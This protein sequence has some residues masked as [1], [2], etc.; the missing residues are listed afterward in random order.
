MNN[1]D[2]WFVYIINYKRWKAQ[3]LVQILLILQYTKYF[4]QESEAYEQGQQ[5]HQENWLDLDERL[6]YSDVCLFK[7]PKT[8]NTIM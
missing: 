6:N 8:R 2:L 4:Y 5:Y 1:I 7:T 3:D